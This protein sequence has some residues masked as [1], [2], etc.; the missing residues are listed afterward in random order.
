MADEREWGSYERYERPQPQRK[1]QA[2]Q[3][4]SDAD[5]AFRLA[6]SE[7]SWAWLQATDPLWKFTMLCGLMAR[8]ELLNEYD[9]KLA[10]ERRGWIKEMFRSAAQTSDVKAMAKHYSARW[11]TAYFW[12]DDGLLRLEQRAKEAA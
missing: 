2:Q 10:D 12:G 6:R 4:A 1:T 5:F 9:W 7:R 8:Y 3:D 11:L